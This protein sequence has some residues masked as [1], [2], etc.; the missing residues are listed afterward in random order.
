MEAAQIKAQENKPDDSKALSELLNQ[1]KVG[2]ELAS[3]Q[4]D[5][6]IHRWVHVR[7]L[8][9]QVLVGEIEKKQSR[10]D[11]CQ[12]YSEQYSSAIKVN[13]CILNVLMASLIYKI[14]NEWPSCSGFV[15]A[16]L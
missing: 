11:E 6:G 10:I 4:N 1:Q 3:P 13:L 8:C 14:N 7:C 16:K 9:F 12:K 15:I 2:Q 5:R